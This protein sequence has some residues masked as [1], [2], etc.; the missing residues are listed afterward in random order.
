MMGLMKKIFG[1]YSSRELKSIYPIVDKIESMADEY[2][3]M[4]DEA[5]RAKTTEFKERLQNGETLDDILPEAFATVRE[6]A[7][8]VL[9]MRPY[10]VQLVGGIVLHQGRI[11]E[12]KTGEG[13]TLVATLPAYLNA[14]TGRGVHIVTVN[15]YLAKRDSEWM[16]KVHRFLGLKVGL[17]VHG[18]TTKERQAAYA[19]DITYGTNNEMGFDYL[20]DNMC[21][22]STELVQRGHAF[23]IVDE[24]DSILIDEAR[25]PLIIS[26]QGEKS[27][28]L[29]D[30]AEMFVSRL[31]KQAVVQVDNKEEEDPAEADAD[32]IVD[33]KAK[34]AMLTARGIAKAEEFFHVENLSD[35]EN[36]TLSHHINQAIKAHGVMKRDIDYV[37]KD[38]EVII[39]DEFTGRLM[40][41]RR[42]SNGLHQAIEAKEH[43][44]VASENKTLA[45]I[46]F[47]NYFRLYDKL[48]GMT[49]TAMTEQ[50]EFGTIYELDIVEIPTNRPNQRHDHH[51]VVYK[52]EAGKYR[53]VIQQIKDCHA[54]GQ[55]VLVGTVSIEKNEL[56]SG[57]LAREGIQHNLLNAKNHEKEAEIVAQ[58]GK[59]GA[60]TVATNMAG[61]G[62]DIMLGGNA[63]YLARADLVKAGY[64][65][66]VIADATGYAETDN[67]EILAARK[68]FAEKMAQH[69]A[70]IAEEAEKVRAAGGLFI[71]GTER[72]ES[73][74][75]D[76]QL[77]GRAGRQGDPGETRFYISLEDDLMRLFGGERIQNM[78]EKFDL[79]EDT[80]IE[81]KMLTKAI[82]NAQ[83]TV[84]SRNFQ[85]RKSVLE[86]DDVMNKQREIIYQQR[87][88][89]L[90]GKDL[91]DTILSMT[92]NAIA[93]HVAMAFG[94]AQALDAAGCREMLRG[95]E[96]LYFPK[97]TFQ[98][99]EDDAA[100]K[101]QQDFTDL[102]LEAA[103][104]T[105]EAKEAEIGTPLMRE[106]ERVIMLRVVDEYWMDHIDAMDD[107]KQ[108]IRLRAYANTDPVIAYKQESLT[109]FEEMVSAI[110]TETVRRM[111]SVRLKKDE[112]V[113]RERVAKGMVEN[114][115]GDG[116]APKKQPVK[117]NKIGRNDPCPCG[118]GL[119]WKKCTCKEY[120][121]N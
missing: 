25:T 59:F 26:G 106:L 42:Y 1:D 71:I 76:N 107:L 75:I 77:R 104:K 68:L 48:S 10:R 37:V 18:L 109:M 84:E 24:V 112:E 87:R 111:F 119:K 83:T 35:P 102:F 34:T 30:M 62:T 50:E 108:G 103:E 23:A 101:T 45:T 56:L 16:G 117:V 91:K 98:F 32:Y 20:R 120:H 19:A 14:L 92:R 4:S 21:I 95:L 82:E 49:G 85:S 100:D 36:A 40:F 22:Y 3:A 43:V 51:D 12:M 97:D 110:Q 2:K 113:K 28:Q 90:D 105:Y 69:K 64:S 78:M 53:A 121:D 61:R 116:T 38:G 6:A 94:E 99:T 27:T 114:V 118:S 55:P 65:D 86:Y 72:H 33:E 89:V 15:D 79:D 67:E 39:V 47:Q 13:K 66:E 54:K 60:V 29:Y 74:R 73:R 96:G 44:T 17:I 9:G 88:E 80:P 46:T 57:L 11:A 115:G 93:D 8:R 52:T 70:V 5:L 31:K 41:G 81:N 7:D 63:E 58:A